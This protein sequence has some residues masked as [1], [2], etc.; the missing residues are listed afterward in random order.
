MADGVTS[1]PGVPVVLV[2]HVMGQGV[3]QGVVPIRHQSMEEQHAR[4]AK[5]KL[6]PAL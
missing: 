5:G 2:I 6:N 3:D 4:G 1:P